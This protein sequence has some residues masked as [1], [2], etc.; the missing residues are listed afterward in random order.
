MRFVVGITGAS[1]SVYGLRLIEVLKH[2]GHE[3][4]AVVTHS[5]W[6]V[7]E[8]ECGVTREQFL[9]KV[10]VLY[11]IDDITAPIASGSFLMDAMI[12]VPCTMKSAGCIA[13]GIGDNLLT[14]A[15]DV[16][17]KEGRPLLLV[18][19][20]TPM[21]AVHLENLLKLARLNVRIV[22]ACPAFY[23]RPATLTDLIDMM[24]GKICDALHVPNH[25]FCRWQGYN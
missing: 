24:V 10:D 25:L 15:A 1:G 18:P 3:I 4:H 22:P 14:R 12:I 13:N 2:E 21:S 17:L 7:M 5:G 11:D 19:R 20:E 23:E 16:T 6:K 8:Y 9:P